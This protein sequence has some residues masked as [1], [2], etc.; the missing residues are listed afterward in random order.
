ME[1]DHSLDQNI[2]W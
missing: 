2:I 1:E